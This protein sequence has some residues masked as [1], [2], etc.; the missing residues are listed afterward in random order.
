VAP[1]DRELASAVPRV[2]LERV[3]LVLAVLVPVVLVPVVL[4]LERVVPVRGD[5]VRADLERAVPAQERAA[6]QQLRCPSGEPT[7]GNASTRPPAA[8]A[9]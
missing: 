5:L 1:A 4:V 2:D 8:R 6:E 9:C 7:K 3:L